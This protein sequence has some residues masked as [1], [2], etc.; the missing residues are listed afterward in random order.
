MNSISDEKITNAIQRSLGLV[1][2][3][4]LQQE[5]I[6]GLR[7]GNPRGYVALRKLLSALEQPDGPTNQA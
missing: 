4:R 3:Q 2:V 5:L 1:L 7:D 6:E